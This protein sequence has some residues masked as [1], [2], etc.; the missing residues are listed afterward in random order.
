MDAG[1]QYTFFVGFREVGTGHFFETYYFAVIKEDVVANVDDN[2][3]YAG[4]FRKNLSLVK[5]LAIP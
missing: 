4:S 3:E 2:D 1:A 5:I